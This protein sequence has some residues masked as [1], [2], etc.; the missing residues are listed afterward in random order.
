MYSKTTYFILPIL[1][2]KGAFRDLK[3]DG[4]INSYIGWE[5]HLEKTYGRYIYVQFDKSKLS[6]I[7][8]NELNEHPYLIDIVK[9]DEYFTFIFSLSEDFQKKVIE[10][11]LAGKYSQINRKFVEDYHPL[12]I[13]EDTYMYSKNKARLILDKSDD[14]RKEWEERLATSLP[15]GAEVWS[16]PSLEQE[17]LDYF[18]NTLQNIVDNETV[19]NDQSSQ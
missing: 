14:I 8:Y 9:G 16:I 15:E 5:K 19:H 18:E 3:K 7:R 11:F 2:L 12:Y 4:F 17:V 1:R 6:D 10:P 13:T